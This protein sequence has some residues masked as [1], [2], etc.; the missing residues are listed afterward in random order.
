MA[1]C[2]V[3]SNIKCRACDLVKGFAVTATDE[4]KVDF[5]F[6]KYGGAGS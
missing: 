2:F 4:P 1:C 3:W 5:L 6:L